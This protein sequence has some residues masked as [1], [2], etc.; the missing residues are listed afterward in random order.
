MLEL[1][2]TKNP[3]PGIS[4]YNFPHISGNIKRTKKADHNLTMPGQDNFVI[5]VSRIIKSKVDERMPQ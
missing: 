1:I 5:I 4:K 2:I 3:S